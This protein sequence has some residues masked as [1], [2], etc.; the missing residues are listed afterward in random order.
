MSRASDARN[1]YKIR[2]TT[3]QH[4]P[5]SRHVNDLGRV[6]GTHRA[7][8]FAAGDEVITLHT[9]HTLKTT[10]DADVANNDR[11]VVTAIAPDGAMKLEGLQEQGII[12]LPAEYIQRTDPET[13]RL[14]VNHAYA[15]TVHKAQGGTLSCS[16]LWLSEATDRRGLYVAMSRGRGANY[17]VVTADDTDE[18]LAAVNRAIHRDYG[19]EA[20]IE[21][22]AR[23]RGEPTARPPPRFGPTRP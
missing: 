9:D 20:A 15:T 13:G 14:P 17:C 16:I 19:W 3:N 10:R 11:W 21:A 23:G 4:R 18:A 12:E 1:R 8:G 5:T 7:R 22:D 6:S 2:Y